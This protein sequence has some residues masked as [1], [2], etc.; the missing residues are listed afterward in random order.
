MDVPARQTDEV[1]N[2]NIVDI[3]YNP[4]FS[5]I[6]GLILI[7]IVFVCAILAV[8]LERKFGADIQSRIG[9]NRVG[10]RYGILQGIA[11]AIK[12][13][14][15]EDIIPAKADRLLFVLAPIIV[16]GSGFM[17]IVAIPF[18]AIVIGDNVYPIAAT[19]MD[20]SII[21]LEAVSALS[22]LGIFMAAYGSNNKYSM[23]A[24]FR[25]TA[26]MIGYE[27]P[28]GV[29]IIGVAVMAQ[30]LDIVEIAKAQSPLWF[31]FLQPLGFVIFFISILADM[32]RLPFDQNEA[33][34]ELV[35]G[36][37]TEY[38]GLRWGLGLFGEYIHMVL[39]ACI[40]VL[41]Y[42]G[43]WNLP[44]FL[45]GIF[46]L[47]SLMPI[48]WFVGKVVAIVLII[49]MLRWALP[50]FRIDQVVDLGWKVLFPLSVL[51]LIWAVALSL[52][53]DMFFGA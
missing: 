4:W 22:V 31:V 51:N 53:F 50:R 9:P 41:L 10:G 11:D 2:M 5:G 45:T 17:M 32:G 40:M 37:G 23:I 24:A 14:T 44:K 1:Y 15:K 8:W 36:W 42:L 38:S 6:V 33:E 34:E 27:V 28:L 39:G 13:F 35:A 3:V 46:V 16:L 47:G 12:L 18:G 29:C 20:I 19:Q 52:V 48:F 26:R 49:I 25:N 21:Y 43:G 30:S 7:G